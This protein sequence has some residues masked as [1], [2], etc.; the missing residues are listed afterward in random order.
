MADIS[1]IDKNFVIETKIERENVKLYD[2]K[3]AP[4]KI[5][6]I[7]H[8]GVGYRRVPKDVAEKTS[9]GVFYL[10]TD[11]TG[12]RVRFITDSPYVIIKVIYPEIITMNHMPLSAS[13]GFDMYVNENGKERYI[14]SFI[15]QPSS[16]DFENVCDFSEQKERLLTINFPLYNKV[17][18]V[19]IGIKDG[20]QL[21]EAPDYSVKLPMVSYGSS[22]TQGGCASRPGNSYQAVISRRYDADYI[23][24]GFSGNAKGED[25][26]RE[27]IASLPMS[28]FIFDYD[29][30][31]TSADH[32]RATHKPI[33][34]AVRRANPDIPIVIMPRPLY[35]LLGKNDTRVNIVR[36]TY[37]A[38]VESGDKNVYYVSIAELLELCEDNGTVDGSHP[39]DLGFKSMAN[40]VIKVLD[41][42]FEI[43]G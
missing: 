41:K 43:K 22:I 40:A 9:D 10:S 39:N 5:Y 24:L 17:S 37:D 1:K 31:A 12:G 7:W 6:G 4:F 8:D 27:Y 11:T 30:N 26:M 35:Q 34:E 38:A 21:K 3:E 19:Y 15:P 13:A 25:S 16:L 28:A 33:Y 2:I 29:F 20:S 14:K 32:L 23:N 36:A 42:L 18:E